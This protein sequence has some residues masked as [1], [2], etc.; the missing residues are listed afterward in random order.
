MLYVIL[1][2]SRRVVEHFITKLAWAG[3]VEYCTA[4]SLSKPLD[5][6]YAQ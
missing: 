4:I 1:R 3:S 5:T 6:V 2:I